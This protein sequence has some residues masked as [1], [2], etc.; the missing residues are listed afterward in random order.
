MLSLLAVIAA[1]VAALAAVVG[2][3]LAS[4]NTQKSIEALELPFL[5]PDPGITDH[6]RLHFETG[7]TAL[8][9]LRVP[10]HNL[11]IGPAILGDVRLTVGGEE[12]LAQPGGEIPFRSG[13]TQSLPF[14]LLAQQEPEL[15]QD[16]ELRIYYTHASGARYMTR[17]HVRVDEA[18]VLPTSFQREPSDGAERRF[19]FRSYAG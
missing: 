1:F 8:L 18:G 5:I 2:T 19:L 17:C 16:G 12:I 11:G 7:N 3:F 6:W 13:E 4:R 10:M 9:S 14:Q 15:E